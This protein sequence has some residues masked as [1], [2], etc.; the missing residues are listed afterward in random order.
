MFGLSG[1]DF[2]E[3]FITL[4]L[5]LTLCIMV[6]LELKLPSEFLVLITYVGKKFFDGVEESRNE[7]KKQKEKK[8]S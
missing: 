4:L 7:L 5:F 2:F 3:S 6:M 1:K 8:P